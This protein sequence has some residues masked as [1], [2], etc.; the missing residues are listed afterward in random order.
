MA[1]NTIGAGVI[2]NEGQIDVDFRVEGNN[3][4]NV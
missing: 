2:L 1:V 4:A 3:N